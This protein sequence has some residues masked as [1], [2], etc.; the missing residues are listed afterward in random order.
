MSAAKT[1]ARPNVKHSLYVDEWK[2]HSYHPLVGKQGNLISTQ[3][4]LCT[5][6][7]L[8]SPGS[9]SIPSA[10]HSP[11]RSPGSAPAVTGAAR[12]RGRRGRASGWSVGPAVRNGFGAQT[13]LLH[14]HGR[15]SVA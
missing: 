15:Q 13:L 11:A 6:E 8:A 12:F 9:D 10:A 1:S 3:Q 2:R 4:V 14:H 7:S 5:P